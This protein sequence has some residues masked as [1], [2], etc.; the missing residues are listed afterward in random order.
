MKLSKNKIFWLVILLVVVAVLFFS[1]R[2][3]ST[4]IKNQTQETKNPLA[5]LI[6]QTSPTPFS[7]QELTIPFLRQQ[8]YESSLGAL[9]KNYENSQ[10]TAFLTNYTSDGLRVNG[11]LTVPKEPVPRIPTESGEVGWPAIIFIHGYIPP[12]QYN[13]VQNYYDYVDYL[14]RNGFVIF[15]IDLRG[16][17]NSEGE[18]GGAYYSADY[19]IDTFNA[20]SALQNS[21][22][23]NPNKI[24]LWGHSMAGNVVMRSFAV[25][26]EI[27]AVV[28]LA[29]AVYS[30]TDMQEFGINDSSYQSP[31]T[32][33]ERSRKRQRIRDTYGDPNSDNFFWQQMAPTNYLDDLKGAIQIHHA[34][35]DT[36][37]NIGYSKNL[38]SLL[39]KTQVP[40]ELQEYSSG[41]H[42]LNGSTFNEAMQKTVKF[43]KKYL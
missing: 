41:G 33:T 29:G 39:N 27:P 10:Y 5:Q 13:T 3:I 8:K 36:V 28:I 23:V 42:N 43:F 17:G 26:P 11:L 24:G 7:F 1:N 37:V 21:D 14:A 35:N 19:I 12:A 31:G 22:F 38:I 30:Y 40:H 6:K 18:P 4:G 9:E 20:Y 15:K 32:S 2:E 16:N 34:V 25:K